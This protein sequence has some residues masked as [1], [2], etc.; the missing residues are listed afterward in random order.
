MEAFIRQEIQKRFLEIKQEKLRSGLV[1]SGRAKSV[2]T[3]ALEG[4]IAQK[5]HSKKESMESMT[6]D[7][8]FARMAAIQIRMFIFAGNDST[9]SSIVYAFHCLSKHPEVASR[10]R[11][12]HD[13]VFG[14]NVNA[15]SILKEDPAIINQC[16]YTLAVVKETLRLYP[17]ASTLR[18]GSAGVSITDRLGNIY[19]TKDLGATIMHQFVHVNPRFWPRPEEF[20]PER[21]LVQPGHE[22]YTAPSSG[23]YRPF[24]HGPRNCIGQTL[25]YNEMRIVLIL[26]ARTFD[27]QPAYEEWD[28][29]QLENEGWLMRLARQLGLKGQEIKTVRGERAYQTVKAG[30]HPA[31]GYPCRVAFLEKC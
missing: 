13:A 15:A 20:L 2:I 17:P 21:W 7:E 4:Y 27:I 26:T 3:L 25:V 5:Q 14:V 6:L 29:L 31:D 16:R 24:E 10:L 8:E 1:Q 30:A 19:P 12:E 23:A 22:L 11:Q 28:T 9:S 18:Q